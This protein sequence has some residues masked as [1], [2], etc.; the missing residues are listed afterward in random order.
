MKSG[1]VRVKCVMADPE[2]AQPMPLPIR[3]VTELQLPPQDDDVQPPA[4]S[5]SGKRNDEFYGAWDKFLA[6][7]PKRAKSSSTPARKLQEERDAVENTAGDGLRVVENAAT[8]Y[9]QAAAECRAK[10]NAIVDECR[11]L[12]Q[13]YRDAIFDL[14][15]NPYCLQNL[16]GRFPKAV[17]KIEPPPWVKRVEDIFDNPQFVASLT[18]LA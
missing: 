4:D 10:V 12:N 13:K 9:Q 6:I 11:R 1:Y 3:I 7:E 14:E 18:V 5:P 2:P 17:E 15:A 8:S 16:N